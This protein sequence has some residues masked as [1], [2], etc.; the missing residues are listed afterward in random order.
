MKMIKSML[1]LCGI[2]LSLS[3]FSQNGPRQQMPVADRVARTIERLKPELNL[4]EPQVKEM[5]P[6]Y[7]EYYTEMDKL[8]SA[9]Q[10]PAPEARQKLTDARDAKLKKILK[11]DQFKK[12]K[13][14]EEQMRQ[15]RRPNNG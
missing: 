2:V 6:V 7:T 8:R 5:E 10:P 9:G 13:E 15:Q 14:L 11:E 3:A 4:T 12:L 1:L